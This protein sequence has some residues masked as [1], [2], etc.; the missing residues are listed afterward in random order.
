[1]STQGIDVHVV[2]PAATFTSLGIVM[3]P[4]RIVN[5]NVIMTRIVRAMYHGLT[6]GLKMVSNCN[7]LD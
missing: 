2:F 7:Y 1:M 4:F 6:K 3:S 5:G